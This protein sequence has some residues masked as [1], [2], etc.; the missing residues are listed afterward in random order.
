MAQMNSVETVKTLLTSAI[1][2]AWTD[3]K[4]I[5]PLY[6][7]Y[8]KE[9]KTSHPRANFVDYAYF[10]TIPEMPEGEPLQYDDF[11]VGEVFT[12]NAAS[13]G[14]GVRFTKKALLD[15]SKDPFGEFS[16]ARLVAA[17]QIGKAFAA[18]ERQKKDLIASGFIS[19]GDSA[20]D[21]EGRKGT[22]RD[23][24]ALFSN[25]H[26]ILSDDSILGSL[27][28]DNLGAA[29]SLDQDSLYTLI[30]AAETFPT[31]EGHVKP[32]PMKWK[33][34]VGPANRDNAYTAV[35]TAKINKL[36]GSADNDVPAV[37]QFDISVVV[38]PFLGASS[39][40][41]MLVAEGSD[42]LRYWDYKSATIEDEP[43]FETKGHR[44]STDFDWL[45]FAVDPSTVLLSL[46]A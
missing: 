22:V 2:T 19:G 20:A 36:A 39:T 12:A 35:E 32:F 9:Y 25:A 18:A 24:L 46:G 44:W 31:L 28:Y 43:D 17:G 8:V 15:M 4:R 30:A 33:L 37:S 26:T 38:N 1:G 16:T 27:T 40:R 14:L 45:A 23:G 11:K 29:S 42:S 41:Y 5:K 13:F 6:T 34:V 21:A 10:T 3:E 7:Q